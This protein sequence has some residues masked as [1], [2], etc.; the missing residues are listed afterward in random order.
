[1]TVTDAP[2]PLLETKLYIPRPRRGVVGRPR[3]ID[4]LGRGIDGKLTLIS[5]PAGFGK[6]TLLAE[7]LA[8]PSDDERSSAWL[9]I[10]NSD[11][12]PT[13]FWS[14]VIAALRTVAP[15]V[16][17]SSVALLGQP[18]PPPTTSVLATLL[19]E[20]SATSTPLVLVLDD[21]HLIDSPEIHEGR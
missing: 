8:A 2:V 7:W 17:A 13:T 15:G 1:M 12:Q 19:N 20:L 9:S 18:Q 21:Y 14:F 6:T 16:G 5:A 11:D 10:D 3:L 4:Q